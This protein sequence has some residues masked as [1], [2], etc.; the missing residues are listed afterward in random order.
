[1]VIF[2][3]ISVVLATRSPGKAEGWLVALFGLLLAF[4]SAYIANHVQIGFVALWF[5]AFA[6]STF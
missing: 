1:M 5:L 3:A 4:V 2:I 6:L